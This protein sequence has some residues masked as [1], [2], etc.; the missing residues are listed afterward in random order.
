MSHT[1]ATYSCFLITFNFSMSTAISIKQVEVYADLT[2]SHIFWSHRP[3]YISH[4]ELRCLSIHLSR[5][6]IPSPYSGTVPCSEARKISAASL[7]QKGRMPYHYL[8]FSLAGRFSEGC[9]KQ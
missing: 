4:F 8:R 7:F 1:A 3:E 2:L 6:V 9:L 5:S